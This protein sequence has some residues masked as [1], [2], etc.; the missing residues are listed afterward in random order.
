MK[1]MTFFH[2]ILDI[3]GSRLKLNSSNKFTIDNKQLATTDDITNVVANPTLVGT[4][5]DLTGLQVGDTKYKV[6]GS[7]TKYK[8]HII[9]RNVIRNGGEYEGDYVY[10]PRA[11]CFDIINDTSNLINTISTLYYEMCGK[12]FA[13]HYSYDENEPFETLESA[14]STVNNMNGFEFGEELQYYL[15]PPRNSSYEDYDY[16]ELDLF[17]LFRTNPKIDT[18]YCDKLYLGLGFLNDE[19]IDEISYCTVTDTVTTL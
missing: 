17:K 18:Q 7:T 5:S 4:E 15:L 12:V 13:S 16:Y 14:I 2:K 11:I 3:F 1:Q 8:H 19:E 10:Y 6:G 9:L